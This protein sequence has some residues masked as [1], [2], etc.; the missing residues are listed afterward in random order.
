VTVPAEIAGIDFRRAMREVAQGLLVKPILE[1][2]LE[3]ATSIR[4][5]GVPKR[6]LG[7]RPPDG[8]FHPSTH[9]TWCRRALYVYQVHPGRVPAERMAYMNVLS[10]TV[11][12]A[13]H[14]LDQWCLAQA[15]VLPKELQRCTVD[16]RC[17]LGE[18]GFLD[19]RT[20]TRTHADGLLALPGRIPGQDLLE[21]KT[22]G[23]SAAIRA[24]HLR[25]LD[26]DLFRQLWP[27]YYAQ[28]NEVQRVS[29]RR[30]TV[31]LIQDLG[32]PWTM[33]EIHQPFDRELAARTEEKYLDV[34]QAVADQRP[35]AHSCAPKE[36]KTCIGRFV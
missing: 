9:P 10:V 12:T 23:E 18:P 7:S 36:E 16:E 35:P 26:L 19:E 15:G 17:R 32:Y 28:A 34:L 31:Y 13:M 1:N 4:F 27:K 21:I 14:G 20:R 33:R 6:E 5:P 2:Y 3:Q 30:Q 11:G 22:V 29:G 8:W 25:D 24:R